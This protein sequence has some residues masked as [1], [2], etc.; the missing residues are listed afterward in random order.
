MARLSLFLGKTS[1]KAMRFNSSIPV[2]AVPET[3]G[4]TF[5]LSSGDPND[6]APSNLPFKNTPKWRELLFTTFPL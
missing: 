4:K 3:S 2:H 5:R 1:L 6:I